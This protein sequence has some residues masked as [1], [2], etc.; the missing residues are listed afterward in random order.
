M[1]KRT[2]TVFVLIGCLAL[3]CACSG[4]GTSTAPQAIGEEAG[5][6][7]GMWD[8]GETDYVEDEGAPGADGILL[9]IGGSALDNAYIVYSGEMALTVDKPNQSAQQVATKLESLGGFIEH[10][11]VSNREDGEGTYYL[12]LR[13][14]PAK[15]DEFMQWLREQG[16]VNRETLN[17]DNISRDYHDTKARLEN[18]RAQRE[19]LLAIMEQAQTIEEI[20]TVRREIDSVQ[21][22]IERMQTQMDNYDNLLGFSCIEVSLFPTPSLA[23]GSSD[24]RII[25]LAQW[26]ENVK[27]A[28]M[29]ALTWT[30]NA[31]AG[32]GVA[33][34]FLIIP[35]FLVGIV[36]FVI[37]MIV[38]AASKRRRAKYAKMHA[39]NPP[40]PPQPM[41][42][43]EGEQE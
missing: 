12:T 38:R 35:L 28:F 15:L 19:Q 33:I 21:E 5:Y 22:T 1:L 2:L 30:V 14:P 16:V 34:S 4:G 24:M 27:S 9:N 8:D 13:V 39:M 23:V 17:A 32:I 20:L 29:T 18:A 3:L 11:S 43:K 6:D 25:T 40:P 10:S 42:P 7:T 26:W 36:V 31:I 37:V 41:P